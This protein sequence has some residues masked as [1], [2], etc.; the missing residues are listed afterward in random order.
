MAKKLSPERTKVN[1]LLNTITQTTSSPRPPAPPAS[2]KR[3]EAKLQPP[4]KPA[5]RPSGRFSSIYLNPEDEKIIRET[6]L[7][8]TGQGLRINDSLIV[9]VALRML[10][11]GSEFIAAYQEA[12]KSDRRS[13]KIRSIS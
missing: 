5:V 9:R 10:H 1:A 12:V 8:C 3:S 11:T 2:V 13:K 4:Q 6:A 7:W